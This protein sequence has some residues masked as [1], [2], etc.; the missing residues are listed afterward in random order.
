MDYL[1]Q[2]KIYKYIDFLLFGFA[3]LLL[4]WLVGL[5][6]KSYFSSSLWIDEFYTIQRFSSKGLITAVTDYHVPNNHVFFS[7]LKS[8]LPFGD[9]YEPFQARFISYVAIIGTI[10]TLIILFRREK[11][12]I[13]GL[14]CCLFLFASTHVDSAM[15]RLLFQARGYGLLLFLLALFIFFIV[16]Y[17]KNKSKKKLIYAS[18]CA[19]LAIYTI[20]TVV[21]FISFVFGLLFLLSER[22]LKKEIFFCYTGTGLMVLSLYAPLLK[23]MLETMKTY[24]SVWGKQYESPTA[25]FKTINNFSVIES[26]E[27]VY[28]FSVLVL[29]L[30]FLL[31]KGIAR[32]VSII[33]SW[34]AALT[35]IVFVLMETPIPR[36]TSFLLLPLIIALYYPISLL[37]V[38]SV[39]LY[40]V[41]S[42]VVM[43]FL[44]Q[45]TIQGISNFYFV[46]LENWKAGASIVNEVFK[47][48]RG[49]V[50]CD[51]RESQLEV[52]LDSN[53]HLIKEFDLD[54]FRNKEICYVSSDFRGNTVVP[55]EVLYESNFL[56]AEVKRGI[57]LRVFSKVFK[58]DIY[59]NIITYDTLLNISE[60]KWSEI[61]V[62]IVVP[63]Q[64]LI[65]VSVKFETSILTKTDEIQVLLL[66]KGSMITFQGFPPSDLD[67][68]Y[69]VA[70]E[71]RYSEGKKPDTVIIR[72][73]SNTPKAIK[74]QNFTVKVQK[75]K[76]Y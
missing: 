34:S 42:I 6:A 57:D 36:T 63:D 9:S 14:F 29:I 27:I 8:I 5:Y 13:W 46:P 31:P 16:A 61:Q 66:E 58:A 71:F 49:Y 75:K 62:P 30:P 69:L 55:K 52:H 51:F 12:Q 21:I 33:F 53:V 7:L 43:V 47:G 68:G 73:K 20:P 65:Q 39:W 3:L 28:L 74:L 2:N 70:N 10:T 17:L 67:N 11:V 32:K 38:K 35:F 23:Q 56:F 40:R 59:D 25:I 44:S 1:K 22:E 18:I 19:V 41:V 76:Y 26:I 50:Y 45:P 54:R 15:L 64:R 37:K 4:S 60:R 48:E 72:V 24:S